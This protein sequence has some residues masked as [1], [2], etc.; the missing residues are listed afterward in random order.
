VIFHVLAEGANSSLL[1][2]HEKFQL[3]VEASK[4]FIV[5]RTED[6][7]QKRDRFAETVQNPLHFG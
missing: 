4:A 2:T 5:F 7:G 3:S 6:F 1:L